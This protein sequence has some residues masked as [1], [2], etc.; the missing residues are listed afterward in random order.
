MYPFTI[1][2]KQLLDL[3]LSTV[4][5]ILKAISG[6]VPSYYTRLDAA[7]ARLASKKKK[8]IVNRELEGENVF[9]RH[10]TVICVEWDRVHV[11]SIGKMGNCHTVG[12]NEAL[13]VSGNVKALWTMCSSVSR[14]FRVVGLDQS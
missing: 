11:V 3:I 14:P 5:F 9:I 13:V 6:S 1:K 7:V 2:S 12:P 8:D 4:T 10:I